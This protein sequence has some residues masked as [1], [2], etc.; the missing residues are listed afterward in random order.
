MKKYINKISIITGIL[1]AFLYSSCNNA[2]LDLKPDKPTEDD[3]FKTEAEF[4][5]ATIGV[6]A[7]LT[8]F[9]Q[10]A[11]GSSI[12]HI[13]FLSGDDITTN[14][15]GEEMDIFSNL[16]STGGRVSKLWSV[17][18]QLIAR[19]NLVGEQIDK[20]PDNLFASKAIKDSY[21][22]EVLF[23]RGFANFYLWNYFSTAPLRITRVTS[24]DNFPIANS[25]DNE[26][27]DQ[28]I[29]DFTEAANLLPTDRSTS[30][31]GRVNKNSANAFLGKCLV[32]KG[33]ITKNPND[34][35]AANQA[36]NKI[37]SSASLTSNFANNFSDKDENNNES[38]FEIQAGNALGG[39]NVWIN[40]DGDINIGDLSIFWGYY[41]KSWA[42]FSQAPFIST[43]KL[44]NAFEEGDP[45]K[46][47]TV[48]DDKSILKYV[49]QDQSGGSPGSFDNY[50][51]LRLADVKLLQAEAILQSGGNTAT[52]IE[53]INEV[54]TRARGAGTVPANY[55]PAETNKTIIMNWIM[56]ER[57][58]E[59]AG[60]GQRWFDL[61]RWHIQ[62]IITLDNNYFNSVG[63]VDFVAPKHLNFPIPQGEL[64][65]NP[66]LVQNKNY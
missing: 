36:F 6:Y 65:R 20:A 33:S 55:S 34:F 31:R 30:S 15:T 3:Y 39:N 27:L 13:Y 7:K 32:F 22:G 24:A 9:Y 61:R 1:S 38:L 64:D 8:D 26:L 45:R 35:S 2:K 66:L 19:A 47:E 63:T 25:K 54:R 56:N 10:Y 41:S 44:M 16:Q 21:K 62:G 17:C 57:F 52:A 42:L 46:S 12:N 23:L 43:V 49:K 28:A 60:E 51:V 5:R 58:L 48:D 40:N 37:T 11:G 50:R 18:Y 59:L 14:D 29:K 4:N 53:K